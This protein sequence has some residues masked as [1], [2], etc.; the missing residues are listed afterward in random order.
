[1]DNQKSYVMCEVVMEIYTICMKWVGIL[2]YPC[3]KAYCVAIVISSIGT[4]LH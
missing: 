4:V 1:M 2:M 3:I